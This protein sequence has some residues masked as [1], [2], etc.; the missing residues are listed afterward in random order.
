MLEAV[1][2]HEGGQKRVVVVE[3]LV[4]QQ[5]DGLYGDEVDV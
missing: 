1:L 4:R 2:Q 3:A 5:R